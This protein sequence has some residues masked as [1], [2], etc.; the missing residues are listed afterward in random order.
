MEKAYSFTRY[1]SLLK[2]Q[3]QRYYDRE[4]AHYGLGA[5]QYYFLLWVQENPGISLMELAEK[6]NYDKATAARSVAKMERLGFVT[7]RED[8][9]DRRV[10]HIHMTPRAGAV[11]LAM[12]EAR[13]RLSGI[14]T[15]GFTT[16]EAEQAEKM[17][18][19]LAQNAVSYMQKEEEARPD[20]K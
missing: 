18:A 16:E 5:G 14:L 1:A 12:G 6:G 2:R 3:C 10:H 19:R 17:L 8:A 20:E 13:K 7:C 15:Q 11:L 4:M 9:K